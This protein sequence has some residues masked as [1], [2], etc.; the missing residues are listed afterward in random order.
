M[1][2][3]L[4]G[5]YAADKLKTDLIEKIRSGILP[6][7]TKIL[8][9]RKLAEVYQISY[10]TVRRALAELV[11]HGYIVR[12][13]R[14]GVF[15]NKNFRNFSSTRNRTIAFVTQDL[16]DGV[17]LKLLSAIEWRARRS[18]Y[19]VLV[20][21]SMLDVNIERGVLE[22][23]L[24]SN[25]SGVILFPV[26][27]NRNVASA[28]NLIAAGIPVVTIDNIYADDDID[29]I[30]CDNFD[31]GYKATEYLIKNG[32]V[33]IVHITVSRENFRC[34]Y[35]AQKRMA[36]FRQ[37]MKD[38]GLACSAENIMYLAWKYT[39]LPFAEIDLEN[40]GYEQARKALLRTRRPTA[41]FVMFDEIAAGVYRAARDLELAIPRDVSVIGINNID[42][43]HQL[44]PNLTTIAQ[45]FRAL[46]IRAVEILLTRSVPQNIQCIKEELFGTLIIRNSVASLL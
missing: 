3:D 22:N 14:R 46:G 10:M 33:N 26:A 24:Y 15:V 6:P 19:F 28:R 36:G 13:A 8:S 27:G 7:G 21:N 4:K 16:Y 2:K 1:Q 41:F 30:D 43:C 32:H 11:Q 45:P 5:N 31:M 44:S 35:V 38:H 40:L 37:A 34:N 23:L 18:G 39:N 17:V 9:E 20:C 25:V 29:S 42:L 12:E